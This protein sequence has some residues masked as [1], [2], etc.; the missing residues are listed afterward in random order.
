[1]TKINKKK[2]FG[3][4]GVRG[5][6]NKFPMTPEIILKLGMSLGS[7][8]QNDSRK[9]NVLIGKDTRL[10]GYMLESA[11]VSGFTSVGTDVIMVGPMPTPAVAMLTH[12]L[13]ANLGVIISASHNLYKDNGIK[14]FGSDGHKISDSDELEIEKRIMDGVSLSHPDLVGRA[15]RLEGGVGRYIE[16]LK[17]NFKAGKTLSGMKIVID[18]ANGA[19][20]RIAPQVLRELGATVVSINDKPNGVNINDQCGSTCP[21]KMIRK[22]LEEGADIG[23][24]LDGDAD[25]L[26]VCDE[27]GCL[28]DGDHLIGAIVNYLKKNNELRKN[29]VVTTSMS[30]LGLEIYLKK[31]GIKLL[32]SEV[33]DKYVL[34]KMISFDTN[35][36][37]E[38]SGH[39]IFLDNSTTG[40]GLLAAIKLLSIMLHENKKSS[41]I[42]HPFKL[43]PQI[44]RNIDSSASNSIESEIVKETIDYHNKQ[45]GSSGRILV[46]Q[47]GT[48]P[49][50]R[51]MAEGTDTKS[52]KEA[53]HSIEKS[54]QKV[55]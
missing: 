43:F 41:E 53:I 7:Y 13:E 32:R 10:S 51:I 15:T 6:V 45:L 27:K 38:K 9:N 24:A 28:V 29:H 33:G 47:S 19:A 55:N 50:I 23:F 11:L 54:F 31:L 1:M 30:N 49:L 26:I 42:F 14:I 25:R 35:F 22:V 17:I 48:E 52:I 18:S 4:D 34:E 46:R 39:I 8:F 5:E 40:D 21:E 12:S 2:F 44:L 3:T 20:Y 16:N 37:A 36:G